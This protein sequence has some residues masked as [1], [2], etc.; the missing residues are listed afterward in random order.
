MASD[1]AYTTRGDSMSEIHRLTDRAA[2]L[3]ASRR[4]ILKFAGLSAGALAAAPLLSACAGTSNS[5]QD[6][7][8]TAQRGGNLRVGASGGASSDSLDAHNPLTNTDFPRV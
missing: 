6:Q 3:H 1:S 8:G 2:G 5:P 4:G 7:A